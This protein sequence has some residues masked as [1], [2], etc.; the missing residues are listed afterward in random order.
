MT[1]DPKVTIEDIIHDYDAGV[2][3]IEAEAK[4]IPSG[5]TVAW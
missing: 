5:L 1:L 3:N 2:K 4:R